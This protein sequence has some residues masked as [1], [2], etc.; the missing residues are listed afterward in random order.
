MSELRGRAPKTNK[1]KKPVVM[2]SGAPGV[3]KTW[4]AIEFPDVY[5]MDIEGGAGEPHYQKRMDANGAAY[6]GPE[7]LPKEAEKVFPAVISEVDMLAKSVHKF[8]TL[9]IDSFTKLYNMEASAAELKVGS[10]YGRDKKEANKPTRNLLLKLNRLDM[11][12]LLI[13]HSVAKFEQKGEQRVESGSTFDGYPKLEYELHLWLEVQK[14]GPKRVAIVRK[15]RLEAF[16]E[17]ETFDWCY[18]EFAKRYGAE[19]LESAH[20]PEVVK[21]CTKEQ[22]DEISSLIESKGFADGWLGKCMDK[23]GIDDGEKFTFD[24]LQAMIDWANTQPDKKQEVV[25]A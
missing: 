3:G 24:Q 16:P 17:G 22:R 18:S 21:L 2:V 25:T 1:P 19:T 9:V 8:K 20:E 5:F 15:S 7:D 14:R 23:A 6:V 10:D 12:T 13:C 4:G 11:T